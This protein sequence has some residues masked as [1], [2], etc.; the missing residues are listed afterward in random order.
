M[1]RCIS[2]TLYWTW[3]VSIAQ[4]GLL[5]CCIA[6]L[7]LNLNWDCS[8]LGATWHLLDIQTNSTYWTCNF[9]H[10]IMDTHKVLNIIFCNIWGDPPKT[11]QWYHSK[12]TKFLCW[13]I[14]AIAWQLLFFHRS[15][16]WKMDP[17]ETKLILQGPSFHFHDYGRKGRVEFQYLIVSQHCQISFLNT[18]DFSFQ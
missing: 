16:K 3:Q 12:Q 17:L 9:L 7:L 10:D 4:Q 2:D 8:L 1:F 13:K 5:Q 15:W 6:M 11:L 14:G 18:L